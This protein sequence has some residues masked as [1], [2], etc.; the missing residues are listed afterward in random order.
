MNLEFC[1]MVLA[2]E[3]TSTQQ[4]VYFGV[5]IAARNE[6]SFLNGTAV[7]PKHSDPV[8]G[9]FTAYANNFG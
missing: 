8:R 3:N 4:T 6:Y 2:R 1:Y 5:G 7:I 9:I